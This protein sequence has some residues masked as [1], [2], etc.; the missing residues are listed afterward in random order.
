MNRE[1]RRIVSELDGKDQQAAVRYKLTFFYWA[2][3]SR[4]IEALYRGRGIFGRAKIKR[5]QKVLVNLRRQILS[6]GQIEDVDFSPEGVADSIFGG[7]VKLGRKH[8]RS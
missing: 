5:D 3:C 8:K 7:I 6:S 2:T 1:I 4:I